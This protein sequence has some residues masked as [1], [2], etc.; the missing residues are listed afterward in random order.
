MADA[1]ARDFVAR[2]GALFLWYFLEKYSSGSAF[3]ASFG[4]AKS[5]QS[6]HLLGEFYLAEGRYEL[7][8]EALSR[9]YGVRSADAGLKVRLGFVRSCLTGS[10]DALWAALEEIDYSRDYFVSKSD[11]E[12]ALVAYGMVCVKLGKYAIGARAFQ[13]VAAKWICKVSMLHPYSIY[14]VN[15]WC[16]IAQAAA[17]GEAEGARIARELYLPFLATA[18]EEREDPLT[19]PTAAFLEALRFNPKSLE[20]APGAINL[21]ST[22]GVLRYHYDAPFAVLQAAWLALVVGGNWRDKLQMLASE[23]PADLPE[24]WMF[25][26]GAH[27]GLWPADAEAAL[28]LLREVKIDDSEELDTSMLSD[29]QYEVYMMSGQSFAEWRTS[30]GSRNFLPLFDELLSGESSDAVSCAR[31]VFENE[32]KRDDRL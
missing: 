7:A 26:V 31:T 2:K 15:C 10:I 32:S 4:N 5:V 16:A 28:T 23:L 17:F 18:P 21:Q 29:D 13:M 3:L 27:S 30:E 19:H 25:V 14:A 22:R 24:R 20:K 12:L 1:S 8:H 6:D 9:A 11:R